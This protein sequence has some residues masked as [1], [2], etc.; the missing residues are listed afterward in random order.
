M[1]TIEEI[2]ESVRDAQYPSASGPVLDICREL[3]KDGRFREIA[4]ALSAWV[5]FAPQSESFV[6]A[7]LPAIVLNYYIA[8]KDI[9]TFDQFMKWARMSP[10]WGNQIAGAALHE[11]ELQNVVQ[12]ILESMTKFAK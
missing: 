8:P 11:I 10:E 12:S 3:S 2:I 9:L 6:K 1:K 7:S 4:V 5:H